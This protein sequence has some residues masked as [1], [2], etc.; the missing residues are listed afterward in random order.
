MF[1]ILTSQSRPLQFIR[2]QSFLTLLLANPEVLISLLILYQQILVL[3]TGT[4]SNPDILIL[5]ILITNNSRNIPVTCGAF[6][7]S[8][9]T[10]FKEV[11]RQRQSF[12][13]KSLPD[14][15]IPFCSCHRR[16]SS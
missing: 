4:L 6:Q 2:D 14:G 16:Q 11:Q 3:S 5:G 10:L 15:T 13:T 7:E 12:K 9:R 8:V 1:D